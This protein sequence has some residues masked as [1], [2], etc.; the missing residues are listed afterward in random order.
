MCSMTEL[1]LSKKARTTAWFNNHASF[2]L[3]CIHCQQPL[4]FS[5]ISLSCMN[6]HSFDMAKQGYFFLATKSVDDKYDHQLFE[7][8]RTIIQSSPLYDL[9]HE[10]LH[11]LLSQ[12]AQPLTVL[13]AGCGEGS[14]LD[15]LQQSFNGEL[16]A[17]AVDLAKAGVQRAS[18]YTGRI[19]PLVAD[20]SRLPIASQ[21]IDILLSILSPAN[22]LEFKRVLKPTGK[23]IK[24][25]PSQYYLGEIRQTL[26]QL[27]Y[28][29]RETYSNTEIR[30]VF[31][32]N[33]EMIAEIPVRYQ[34]QLSEVEKRAL[35][36]MTPLTWQLS[37]IE[38]E[39][40]LQRLPEDITVDV[41]I[42]VGNKTL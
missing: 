28:S 19:L 6:Q 10:R 35:I 20:L 5:G 39:R 1:A 27:G 41:T 25:I 4:K 38:R 33:I 17:I 8:R 26:R 42:L 14:H 32:E 12:Y 21:Q 18:D 30:N 40:L 3:Q 16:T 15:K 24:V 13:D 2:E 37:S 7:A 23:I 9:L 34:V 29:L 31:R 11:E 22:Y 36:A